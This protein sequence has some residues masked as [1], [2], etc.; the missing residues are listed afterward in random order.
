MTEALYGEGGFY[1][2]P[3]GPAGHFRTSATASALYAAAVVRLL[4]AVDAELGFPDRLDLVDMGAGR[5]ELLAAVAAEPQA[6]QPAGR[7]QLTGVELADRPAGLDPSIRWVAA[8]GEIPAVHGLLLANEWLDN[9]PVEVVALGPGGMRLVEVDGA[10]VERLG[11][12]PSAADLAWLATWWP[13]AATAHRAEVGRLRDEAWAAA[14]RRV[15]RGL[16]VAV[17]YALDA[18]QRP[19]AARAGGTLTGYRSGRQVP[20]VPDASMDLTAHVALDACAAAG[21][22]AGGTGSLLTTQRAALRALGVSGERP[23]RGLASADP[24]EYLG[25]LRDAGEA[26]ELTDPNGLGG[27]GWLAQAVG[28][29][30]PTVLAGCPP[31]SGP[32]A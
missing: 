22:A 27:F 31:L 29:P 17:D 12:P 24:T 21:L 2:R 20:P 4:A 30:L 3:E 7:L 16:A 9:V 18:T 15:E 28:A 13:L 1:R 26:A 5:G 19:V 25:R 10:G 6:Q 8:L 11:G 32:G 14:V 23:P